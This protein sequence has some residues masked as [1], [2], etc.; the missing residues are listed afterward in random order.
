MKPIRIFF[1]SVQK[2][3]EQERK[4]L[5]DYLLDDPLLR[6]FFEPFLFEDVPA[7]D[8]RA[9]QLY[10]DEVRN[11]DIYLGLFGNEYGKQNS[12]GISPTHR[13]FVE[14]SKQQKHRLI[15]IK[16]A[17]DKAKHPKMQSLIHMV[18]DQ[19]IRR[20]FSMQAELI[21]ALY[22]SLIQYLENYGT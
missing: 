14:A 4:V 7:K 13:E 9:D 15:F 11:C 17:D 8:Q 20:R 3:F 6:R 19:L 1:S 10:I 2:K 5:R 16:G 18:G 21:S 12:E 22:A